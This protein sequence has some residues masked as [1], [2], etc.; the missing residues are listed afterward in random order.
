MF[1]SRRRLRAFHAGP[2]AALKVS[3]TVPPA[4]N[5]ERRLR[6]TSLSA[7]DKDLA[8]FCD[9]S[10]VGGDGR[11]KRS[12]RRATDLPGLGRARAASWILGRIR[13]R[14]WPRAD[15]RRPDREYYLQIGVIATRPRSDPGLTA[16]PRFVLA[17]P[18]AGEIARSSC[19]E[20]ASA[21]NAAARSRAI[22]ERHEVVRRGGRPSPR[23]SPFFFCDVV[24][25]PAKTDYTSARS[26]RGRGSA[27]LQVTHDLNIPAIRINLRV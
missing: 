7:L 1:I 3:L 27:P 25:T 2:C 21:P 22:R 24:I 5:Y 23:S 10:A 16:F 15:D 19:L 12:G 6:S 18:S 8:I 11:R 17:R 9:L 14:S 20:N 4:F 13:G 26:R